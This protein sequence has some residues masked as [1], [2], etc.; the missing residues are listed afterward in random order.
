MIFQDSD[1][2]YCVMNNDGLQCCVTGPSRCFQGENITV[3]EKVIHNGKEY[4]VVMIGDGAF[5]YIQGIT[6]VVLPETLTI[7]GEMAFYGSDCLEVF[8]PASVNN[9]NPTSFNRCQSLKSFHVNENNPMFCSADGVLF[10]KDKK[11]LL[12]YPLGKTS[13]SYCVPGHVERIKSSA[14]FGCEH[15]TFVSLPSSLLCVEKEAFYDC[16]N[17]KT[18]YIPK[19]SS[20]N[21]IEIGAFCNC[22]NLKFVNLPDSLRFIGNRAFFMCS[23]LRT[24]KLSK[25]LDYIG[26]F[27]FG[28]CE[29]LKKII[30]LCLHEPYVTMCSFDRCPKERT[31]IVISNSGFNFNFWNVRKLIHKNTRSVSKVS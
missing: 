23:N 6:T 24:V 4:T 21:R 17:L 16:I 2:S 28:C 11:V 5:C 19:S 22:R 9:I 8:L 10:S 3:P 14:F 18:L 25:M 26:E 29:S 12:S 1:F 13:S 15:L 31:L 30:C 27:A 7:I 20:L